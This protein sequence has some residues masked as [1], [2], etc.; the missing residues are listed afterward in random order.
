MTLPIAER[1]PLGPL[2]T[3]GVG[4]AARWFVEAVDEAAVRAAHAWARERRVPLRV[5]GGGSNLVVADAGVDALVVR[6]ALR[7]L[8]HRERDGAVEL[9]A[10]AGEP[11][12]GVVASSVERGWAGLE[13]LSGI[14]GL[15]GATPIQNVGAY[16]QE[17]SD[18]VVAVRA[19]DTTTGEIAALGAADCGFAYRDSMFKR[20]APGRFVV[21]A[22]T[23]RLLPGGAPTLTY[24]DVAR[25]LAG[26]SAPTLAD[27]RAAVLA[28]RRAKSMT[29]DQPDDVNR[30]S[31][32]SFFLNPIV[33]AAQAEAVTAR[34]GD[35]TMPRWPQ[36]DGRVK[37]SAA[38]LIE[39]AGFTRGERE[40]AVGLSTRHT[41]AIVA[42]D[43][44]RATDVLAFARRLKD[45]VEQRF[46]VRLSPEPVFWGVG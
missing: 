10:A 34:A 16:G 29:L 45:G 44:A 33:E 30:R 22:V 23:Y 36:P 28:I 5:L 17:V 9:T 40:G 39:H 43:G 3:L 25:H 35:P 19:L 26:R 32:G 6:I 24:A 20:E 37:L 41:L 4:G 14:P 38:W 12:D 2:T 21:L 31:C 15:V 18:T 1:V 7:G 11:W 27:T 8:S 13:C 42:H 46:G